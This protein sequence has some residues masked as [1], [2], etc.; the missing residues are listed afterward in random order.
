MFFGL[1]AHFKSRTA[2]LTVLLVWYC[3]EISIL[4]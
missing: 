2:L 3:S 4:I 1:F